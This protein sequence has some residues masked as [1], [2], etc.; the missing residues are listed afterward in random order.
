MQ[1]V[2]TTDTGEQDV[3]AGHAGIFGKVVAR[4]LQ[5]LYFGEIYRSNETSFT[6]RQV[7][8]LLGLRT[9]IA[10]DLM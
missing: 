8:H 1:T 4:Q 7:V 10:S 2:G 6:C 5:A 9:A 3:A